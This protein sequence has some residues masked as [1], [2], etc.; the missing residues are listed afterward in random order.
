MEEDFTVIKYHGKRSYF[1]ITFSII[2]ITFGFDK[3]NRVLLYATVKMR[4]SSV[5]HLKYFNLEILY[6][7]FFLHTFEACEQRV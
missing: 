2:R 4:L 7:P 3:G 5:C 6:K 1:K